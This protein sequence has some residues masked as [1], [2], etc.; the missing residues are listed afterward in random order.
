MGHKDRR[1]RNWREYNKALTQRGS[2]TF[3][4]S[5]DVVSNWRTDPGHSAHGNQCYS[6]AVIRCALVLRQLFRLPF[7]ATQGLMDSI[8]SLAQ[9]DLKAPDYTTLCRRASELKV[10]FAIPM[11]SQPIHVL[12]DSTGVRV[13]G[14]HEWKHLCY[15]VDKSRYHTWRKLH[16][17]MDAQSQMIL[18]MTMT[19]STR[20]DGNYLP[21]LIDDIDAAIY[22]IT[23][24]GAYDKRGCYEK[25]HEREAEPIFP[26]QHNAAPQ[27]RRRKKQALFKRDQA[28]KQIGRGTDRPQRLKQWKIQHNYHRRSLIETAM[29]RMKSIF[30]DQMRARSIQNQITDLR[31]RC[32]IINKMNTLGMPKSVTT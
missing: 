18:S 1:I 31:I 9:I 28:I 4:F 16:I 2:L 6:D 24:D 19:D 25:A 22:Q 27:T 15:G 32:Y 26:P 23:G 10:D 8:L 14:A 21:G 11:F 29:W 17:A 20:L 30:T 5:E 3:W 7:R 13:L 12:V